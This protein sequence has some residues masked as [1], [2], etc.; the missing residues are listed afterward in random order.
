MKPAQKPNVVP[1]KRA[2]YKDLVREELMAK[3]EKRAQGVEEEEEDEAQMSAVQKQEKARK[4]LMSAFDDSDDS[5]GED[6]LSKRVQTEEEKAA[7]EN[8]YEAF[9]AKQA[10]KAKDEETA[11]SIHQF[12]TNKDDLNETDRFLRRFIVDKG[13]VDKEEQK[14]KKGVVPTYD[15]IVKDDKDLDNQA[16][17]EAKYNFRYEEP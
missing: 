15:E 3:A 2:T 4:A 10:Q 9:V 13:W 5:E 8:E 16:R 14:K 7:F 11:R 1:A 6:I 12:W 17:F